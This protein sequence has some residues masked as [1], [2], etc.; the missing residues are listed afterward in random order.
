MPTIRRAESRSD[1][2]R[3]TEV[4]YQASERK[5][6]LAHYQALR[7]AHPRRALGTWWLLEEGGQP[8]SSLV[9]HT[10][11]LH[12]PEGVKDAYGLGAVATVPEAR[13]GGRARTLCEAV[14]RDA[15]AGGRTLGL[16][17]SAIPPPYYERM[18]F[19]ALPAW[20]HT[21]ERLADIAASGPVLELHPLEP[22]REVPQLSA[23]YEAHHAGDVHIHRD[24]AGFSRSIHL[25]PA[26]LYFGVG[27]PLAGYIRAEV[28]ETTFEVLELIVPA[29]LAARADGSS[30]QFWASDYF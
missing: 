26:D 16:L 12:T 9:C 1:R 11:R 6:P 22:Q 28:E 24:L 5:E 29:D 17:F 13:R 30:A 14:I 25:A 4:A 20:R 2:L 8:L 27:D 15:E 3:V 19:R 23:L 21:S 18:G 10:L 7:L